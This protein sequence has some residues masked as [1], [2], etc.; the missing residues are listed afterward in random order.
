MK[1][2]LISM[3][4]DNE[5]SL[6]EKIQYVEHVHADE[7]YK[8]ESIELLNQEKTIRSD[9]MER[10]PPFTFRRR[11]KFVIPFLRPAGLVVSAAALALLILFVFMPV[12]EHK[13]MPYRFV[14]YRPDV[15]KVE[16]AGSFTGWRRVSMERMGVSGYWEIFLNIA[17]GEHRFTYI[18]DGDERFADPTARMRERDDF[19]GENSIL[20]IGRKT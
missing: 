2:Y 5:L 17:D 20:S 19:G 12:K 16:I 10:I 3:F 7:D 1:E 9:V 13:N 18:L 15:S 11:K 6:D 14:I 8:D 4:I